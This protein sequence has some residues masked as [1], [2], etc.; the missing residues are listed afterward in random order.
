MAARATS[1][2]IVLLN[3]LLARLTHSKLAPRAFDRGI[4]R[5]KKEEAGHLAHVDLSSAVL[6]L[7]ELCAEHRLAVGDGGGGGGGRRRGHHV[8]AARIGGG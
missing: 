2:L 6:Q 8:R 5:A 4:A 1:F 7:G 3:V